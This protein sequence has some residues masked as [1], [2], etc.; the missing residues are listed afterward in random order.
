MRKRNLYGKR[1]RNITPYTMKVE[2]NILPELI[3][4]LETDRRLLAAAQEHRGLECD[5]A[6]I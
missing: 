6:R 4:E 2:D 3:G 5:Q 1:D